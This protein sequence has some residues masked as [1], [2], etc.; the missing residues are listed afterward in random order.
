[1]PP[2]PHPD[3]TEVVA[4]FRVLETLGRGAHGVVCKAVDNRSG[5]VVAIKTLR[6]KSQADEQTLR[7]EFRRMADVSH[8]NLVLP[9]ELVSTDGE[10][11]LVM[12]YVDGVGFLEAL[13]AAPVAERQEALDAVLVQLVASLEELHGRGLVH[14]DVKP[15]NILVTRGGRA[16]LLDYGLVAVAAQEDASFSG[17][18]VYIAPEV[19]CGFGATAAADWYAVGTML[20]ELLTGEP[21]YPRD[22]ISNVAAKSA[23]MPPPPLDDPAVPPELRALTMRLLAV[24]PAQRAGRHE[25]LA[26]LGLG[27]R[28]DTTTRARV[29]ERGV[30]AG[31]EVELATLE[32]VFA[33]TPRVSVVSLHGGPGMGKS[34][35]MQAWLD[36]L[37]ARGVWVLRGRCYE[38]DATPYQAMDEVLVQIAAELER[39]PDGGPALSSQQVAALARAFPQVAY[40]LG[41]GADGAVSHDLVGA[42]QAAYAAL[43]EVVAALARGRRVVIAIDDLQWGDADSA[44]LL[45]R[46]SSGVELLA[47]VAYRTDERDTSAFLRAFMGRSRAARAYREIIVGPLSGDASR[48]VVAAIA[49]ELEVDEVETLLREAE[50]CP[51]L[52]EMNAMS[53][54]ARGTLALLQLDVAGE[55]RREQG[56]DHAQGRTPLEVDTL[57]LVAVAGRPLPVRV[58]AT[59]SAADSVTAPLTSLRAS[60]MVRTSGAGDALVVDAYHARIRALVLKSLS[61]EARGALNRRLAEALLANSADNELVARY[62]ALSDVPERA[63]GYA[64]EAAA[65]ALEQL[66][67]EHAATL[68]R[69]AL[70]VAPSDEVERV[71]LRRQLARALEYA[72][73]GR[74]AAQQLL[75]CVDAGAPDRQ[76][77]LRLAADQLLVTGH[78]EAAIPIVRRLLR[79]AGGVWPESGLRA[80]WKLLTSYVRML[81]TR[82]R[83][84]PWQG[85]PIDEAMRYRVE[86]YGSLGRGLSSYDALRAPAFVFHAA[87]LA[88]RHGHDALATLGMGYVAFVVGLSGKP[89]AL[90]QAQRWLSAARALA[91]ARSDLHGGY[92]ADIVGGIIDVCRLRWR[93]AIMQLEDGIAGLQANVVGAQW[94]IATA[95]S[96]SLHAYFYLGDANALRVRSAAYVRDARGRGDLALETEARLYEAASAIAADEVG[97]LHELVAAAVAPWQSQEFQY[98]HWIAV[99]F[100]TYGHIY[101]AT[102]DAAVV[103]AFDRAARR[104][105]RAG[106]TSMQVVRVEMAVLGGMVGLTLAAGRARTK[107]VQH[108]LKA[109]RGEV[110]C[111]A[112]AAF[113]LLLEVGLGAR[114]D[115]G[116]SLVERARERFEALD[117]HAH[118]AALALHLAASKDD[119]A[120]YTTAAVALERLGVRA[121]DKY[122]RLIV[123]RQPAR[124]RESMQ[125]P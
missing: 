27:R 92:F 2:T 72:G 77:L 116:L 8:P 20:Y 84:V 110:D 59:A 123:G 4:R 45:E 38:R 114:S 3:H 118:A 13:R 11:A 88:L 76:A 51:F 94:E 54:L 125:I 5:S 124:A 97:H 93:E 42:R 31:R 115:G 61:H 35:V 111:P 98:P 24:D 55:A 48:A 102:V 99:R 62:F 63:V 36:A 90:A 83:S 109:L 79:A 100:T 44:E 18:P 121:P 7:Q 80:R 73:R 16:V 74:D 17:T 60:R 10:T 122:S 112:A 87:R 117:M 75:A 43:A 39:T 1:M 96:T 104:A 108:A 12:E 66:A 52:L 50:G 34:T 69:M 56:N 107:R 53:A 40:A 30:L 28:P 65:R 19:V 25:V 58:L 33:E 68:Y 32:A 57:R 21:P 49:P 22:T 70:D 106:L 23:G 89:K 113:A 37:V 101:D 103:R 14:R 95:K 46:L 64:Q 71:G 41:R 29:P 105:R 81:A 86:L 85:A 6:M 78:L 9:L 91:A 15:A 26:Y 119:A 82:P 47:L 120:G 67:F